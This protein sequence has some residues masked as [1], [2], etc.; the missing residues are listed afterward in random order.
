[1]NP[2]NI[3]RL[4]PRDR[5]SPGPSPQQSPTSSRRSGSL[6]AATFS[7]S[8]TQH[9]KVIHPSTNKK[10]RSYPQFFL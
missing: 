4:R 9:L 6:P 10:V 2:S 7:E 3:G 5:A 1:M 8:E